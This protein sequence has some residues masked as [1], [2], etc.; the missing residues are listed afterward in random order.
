MFIP[1]PDAFV[2]ITLPV[3]TL[4]VP[5]D[6]VIGYDNAVVNVPAVVPVIVKLPF[7]VTV[8]ADDVFVNV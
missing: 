4:S 2:E 6:T 3:F 7:V 8:I 5:A 1:I